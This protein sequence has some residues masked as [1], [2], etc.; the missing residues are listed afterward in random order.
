MDFAAGRDTARA[1]SQENLDLVKRV[2]AAV[3]VRP[4]P[5]FKT[6][7]ALVSPDHVFIPVDADKLDGQE[8]I[9]SEGYRAWLQESGGTMPWRAELEGAV[10]LG[11][12][13]VLAVQ[14]VHFHGATSGIDLDERMW[15]VFRVSKGKIARTDA[16]LDPEEALEAAG[17]SE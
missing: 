9:G 13:R 2:M 7:N 12:D 10:D 3:N 6:I 17:L 14:T 15:L 1:M 16:F 8:R 4:R 5:D 11:P